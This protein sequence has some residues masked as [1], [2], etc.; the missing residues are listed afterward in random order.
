MNIREYTDAGL[1]SLFVN[2]ETEIKMIRARMSSLQKELDNL[3]DDREEI[4]FELV[5][6]GFQVK[7]Q[8]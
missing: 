7:F 6:R 2:K 8:I 5:E 3:I 1:R 4:I